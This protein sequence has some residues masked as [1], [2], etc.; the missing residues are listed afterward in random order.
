M[1]V[2][3]P[4]WRVVRWERGVV[5]MFLIPF[6]NSLTLFCILFYSFHHKTAIAYFWARAI[7]Q[8]L[9]LQTLLLLMN[10]SL[11]D[12]RVVRYYLF[13]EVSHD[14]PS[15]CPTT[16]YLQLSHFLIHSLQQ[17]LYIYSIVTHCI[18]FNLSRYNPSSLT[19]GSSSP[20]AFTSPSLPSLPSSSC[21]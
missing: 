21:Y 4:P 15:A 18:S 3:F 6:G 17:S 2:Q 11:I 9:I 19:P 5:S 10:S 7:I 14:H 8:T 1:W 13:L 20:T 16:R 12:C